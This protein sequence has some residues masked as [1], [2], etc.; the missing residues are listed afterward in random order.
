[1]KCRAK[2]RAFLLRISPYSDSSLVLKAFGRQCGLL[3]LIAKGIRKKPEAC[4]LSPLCIYEL[5]FYESSDSGLCLLADFSLFEE[6]DF[7]SK[8][9]NWTAAECALEF[10]SQL[11]I[12]A[13]EN[14]AWYE[15]LRD[16]LLY[17]SSLESNAV[18]IWW[19]LLLRMFKMLGISLDPHLCSGCLS[20][21]NPLTAWEKQSGRLFCSR[22]L[23][24]LADPTRYELL[25][26][27][28]AKI[29]RLLPEIGQHVDTLRP[30]RDSVAQLNSLFSQ[31]YQAHF[32]KELRLRSLDVLEQ[33]YAGSG[34]S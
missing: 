25:R 16:Y 34:I 28:S 22:C 11:L 10:Y 32:H 27:K 19:R 13:D 23:D 1:M 8:L 2:D 6:F 33:L 14:T 7:T 26:S 17:L 5:T 24:D 31:Y 15:L 4:L 12:P 3:S 29:L 21:A 18:L 20:T 30:D 9:E